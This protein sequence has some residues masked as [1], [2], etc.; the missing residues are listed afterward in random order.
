MPTY[1]YEC[2]TC[3]KVFEADQR[4]SEEPLKDCS[5]GAKGSLRRLIQPTAVMFKG[6][7]FHINDYAAKSSD[8]E[9][10]TAA[11]P[12]KPVGKFNVGV[13]PIASVSVAL[14]FAAFVSVAPAG[15]ATVAVFTS[16][17]VA[18]ALSVALTV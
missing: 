11:E 5:C 18:A 8:S 9:S 16:E 3:Q 4:I 2:K 17:P 1:V 15:A 7:G 6:A 14:L 12:A 10:S 13:P